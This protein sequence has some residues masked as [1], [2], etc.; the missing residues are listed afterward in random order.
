MDGCYVNGKIQ[1]S[2][3]TREFLIVTGLVLLLKEHCKANRLPRRSLLAKYNG[4]F[5]LSNKIY[6]PLFVPSASFLSLN[7]WCGPFFT[8]W[9]T[10][11]PFSHTLFPQQLFLPPAI[12]GASYP[13]K[14]PGTRIAPGILNSQF[15]YL[16]LSP[17]SLCRNI[18]N[19]L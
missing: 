9:P 6:S 19:I 7:D 13:K 4:N 15:H 12:K 14:T 10:Q 17:P 8:L 1:I 18:R 5:W 11:E 3:P 16:S 2:W